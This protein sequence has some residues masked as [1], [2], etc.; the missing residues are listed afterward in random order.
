M[1]TVKVGGESLPSTGVFCLL[2]SFQL[3][4]LNLY[5]CAFS[6]LGIGITP[7]KSCS[8]VLVRRTYSRRDIDRWLLPFDLGWCCTEWKHHTERFLPIKSSMAHLTLVVDS[9]VRQR[10]AS[11]Q[12]CNAVKRGFRLKS[13]TMALGMM[14]EFGCTVY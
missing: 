1:D 9:F 3:R 14:Y 2:D 4:W 8:S 10:G 11:R 13:K 6:A 7:S 5:P 12:Q